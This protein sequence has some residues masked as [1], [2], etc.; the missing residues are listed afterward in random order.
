MFL[1]HSLLEAERNFWEVSLYLCFVAIV[2]CRH[3][4]SVTVDSMMLEELK[5]GL[6]S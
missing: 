6:S 4:L 3:P 5:F 2:F 1:S